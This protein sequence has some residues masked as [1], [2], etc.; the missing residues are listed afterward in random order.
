MKITTK[1]DSLV[2]LLE[3][4]ERVWAFK[5]C[6]CLKV[7]DVTDIV[8]N[9]E[10]PESKFAGFKVP[11]T[12][13]PSLFHAGSFWRQSGWDF[14]YLKA[15]EPGELIIKTQLHK[16]RSIHLTTTEATAFDVREWFNN[17]VN[18]KNIA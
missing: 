6:I 2:I 5:A 11:G 14:R 8:W 1:A 9:P 18:T 3:G 15:R 13:I 16:Y 7:Q 10:R 4:M 12:G 17:F